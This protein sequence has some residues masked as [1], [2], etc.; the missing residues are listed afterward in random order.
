MQK[1][2]KESFHLQEELYLKF[3]QTTP[4]KVKKNKHPR[5][6]VSFITP[7]TYLHHSFSNANKE[8]EVE[9]KIWMSKRGK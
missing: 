6:G 2:W 4:N 7:R 8:S 5:I 9:E 1:Y 3:G